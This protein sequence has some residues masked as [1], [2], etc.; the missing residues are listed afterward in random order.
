MHRPKVSAL[1]RILWDWS[2]L[3]DCKVV[4]MVEDVNAK[5]NDDI[6]VDSFNSEKV[7]TCNVDFQIINQ[8]KDV[9][10]PRRNSVFAIMF[11][12]TNC[13]ISSCRADVH[14]RQ[15]IISVSVALNNC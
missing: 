2:F 15:A 7:W 8:T 1:T 9:G 13:C 12:S 14:V 11:T 6:E 3:F 5:A 10:S 4:E